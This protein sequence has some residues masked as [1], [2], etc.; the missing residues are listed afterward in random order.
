MCME[1]TIK[2]LFPS[3]LFDS[4]CFYLLFRE[5]ASQISPIF[6]PVPSLPFQIIIFLYVLYLQDCHGPATGHGAPIQ[7]DTQNYLIE[8]GIQNATH[9]EVQFRRQL[10]TCDPNDLP[11][12][13]SIYLK[14]V[15][16]Y[17]YD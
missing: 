9:T 1:N 3:R 7:D 11:I 14:N 15:Y 16:D 10:E 12:G 17:N 2:L 5:I 13:V 8:N 6:Y 4:I